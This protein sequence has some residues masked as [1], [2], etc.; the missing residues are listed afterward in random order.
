MASSS[1]LSLP[2]AKENSRTPCS[3]DCSSTSR[4]FIWCFSP[5][6]ARVCVSLLFQYSCFFASRDVCSSISCFSFLSQAVFAWQYSSRIPLRVSTSVSEIDNKRTHKN[7]KNM[8]DSP[9]DTRLQTS[10]V[11]DWKEGRINE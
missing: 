6:I 7:K 9:C 4:D 3:F 8:L 1:C 10:V 5:S 11:I 2:H